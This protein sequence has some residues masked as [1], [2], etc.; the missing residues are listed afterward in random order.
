MTW[1]TRCVK[2][3]VLNY[4][5][6][7][8]TYFF[9]CTGIKSQRILSAFVFLHL[10]VLLVCHFPALGMYK[11]FWA[12][13][14]LYFFSLF[15]EN[16]KYRLEDKS[17]HHC[18]NLRQAAERGPWWTVWRRQLLL[19]PTAGGFARIWVL[20][21]GLPGLPVFQETLEIQ[22]CSI[23]NFLERCVIKLEKKKYSMHH[24]FATCVWFRDTSQNVKK[25]KP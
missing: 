19:A 23:W 14:V 12:Q 13:E 8:H 22:I 17:S 15:Y 4:V 21:P 25:N 2:I 1:E 10:V 24:Q 9:I 16:K 11:Y 20:A 3:S 5:L 7:Q 18:F 6:S